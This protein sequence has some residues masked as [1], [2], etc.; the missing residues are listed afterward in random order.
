MYK[1]LSNA[2]PDWC[3]CC[4]RFWMLFNFQFSMCLIKNSS[5]F[6]GCLCLLLN[7]LVS[8]DE[9]AVYFANLSTDWRLSLLFG[10]SCWWEVISQVFNINWDVNVFDDFINLFLIWKA[11]IFTI[12]SID[13][14]VRSWTSIWALYKNGKREY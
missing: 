1:I 9:T 14:T 7:H 11:A 6:L 12:G 2:N 8:A 3:Q 10:V 4:R 5:S 13:A